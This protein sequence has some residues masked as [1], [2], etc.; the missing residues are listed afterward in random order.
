MGGLPTKPRC[1]FVNDKGILFGP[2]GR[3]CSETQNRVVPVLQHSLDFDIVAVCAQ[4]ER[5]LSKSIKIMRLM[6]TAQCCP[7]V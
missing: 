6:R 5:K 1:K 3:D 7:M 4:R 2:W